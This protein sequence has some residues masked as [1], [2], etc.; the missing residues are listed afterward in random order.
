MLRVTRPVKHA[1]SMSLRLAIGHWLGIVGLEDSFWGHFDR[2]KQ[3]WESHPKV[4]LMSI[5][6]RKMLPLSEETSI[7][8][9]RNPF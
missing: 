7:P 6:S 1:T 8:F 5:P 2:Y 4:Y 3:N 9:Y